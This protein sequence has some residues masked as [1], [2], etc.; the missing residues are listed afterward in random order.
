[1]SQQQISFFVTVKKGRPDKNLIPPN[2]PLPVIYFLI[3]KVD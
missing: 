3:L 2:T 1:M